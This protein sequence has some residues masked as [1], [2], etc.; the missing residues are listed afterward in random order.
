MGRFMT[1]GVKWAS[2]LLIVLAMTSS[3][4]VRQKKAAGDDGQLLSIVNAADP[5]AVAQLTHGFYAVESNAWRWTAKD[6]TVTLHRPDGAAQNGARLEVKL[7]VPELVINRLGPISLSG[8]VN[9][10]A[11]AP[12]TFSKSGDYT[13]SRDIPATALTTDP[14]KVEFTADKALPPSGQDARELA[15]IV[16][17][18]ALSSK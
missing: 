13:Y 11:L 1:P 17:R 18:V 8:N 2:G 3:G 7:A 5:R 4:C 6:F 12:D 9:G 10:F 14:V 15:V 16:S